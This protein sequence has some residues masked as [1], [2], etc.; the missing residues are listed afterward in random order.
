MSGTTFDVL[1]QEGQQS[2]AAGR[3]G[4]AGALAQSHLHAGH[5][6]LADLLG[7][8]EV[9]RTRGAI[10]VRSNRG[11]RSRA[12]SKAQGT[13]SGRLRQTRKLSAPDPLRASRTVP[14]SA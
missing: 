14:G 9:E 2:Q 13:D 11:C 7:D 5:V 12:T 4:R 1:L 8:E 10:A 6:P 3:W